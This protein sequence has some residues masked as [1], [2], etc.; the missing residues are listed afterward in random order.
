MIGLVIDIYGACCIVEHS[1]LL[2]AI[3]FKEDQRIGEVV[4]FSEKFRVEQDFGVESESFY[5]FSPQLFSDGH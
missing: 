5:Y 4:T 3:S 1:G 2:F